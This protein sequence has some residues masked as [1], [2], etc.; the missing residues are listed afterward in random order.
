MIRGLRQMA[1]CE[2]VVLLAVAPSLARADVVWVR[3]ADHGA[4]ERAPREL[5]IAAARATVSARSLERRERRGTAPAFLASDLPVEP[6]YVQALVVR[7]FH[8][9]VVSRWL[10]AASVETAPERLPELGSLP[11]VIGVEPV[12]QA[13]ADLDLERP[14]AIVE[15]MGA[16]HAA[17]V[18][19]VPG[20]TSF[21]GYSA[22]QNELIEADRLHARGL[23][24]HGV[25]ITMLDTG[26][27]ET[28]QVFDSLRVVARR[29]FIHGDTV[30]VNQPMQDSAGQDSHGT[31]TLSVIG[32]DLPGRLVGTAFGATFA[33]GKTEDVVTE[34]PVEMDYWQA[35]AEWADSLGADVISSS[36]GYSTF[37]SPYPSYTYADM[38]GRTTVVTL[39][40]AE[41]ARRGIVV[42]TAQGNAGST[43]WHYLIAPADGDTVCAVGATDSTGAIAYFSS[44]GPSADGRVKPDVCGMGLNASVVLPS[45]DVNIVQANG[46][47]FSTPAMA[48]VAA[49]LL[50]AHPGWTPFEVIQSLRAT[51]TRF[52]NPDAQL[53]YGVARAADAVDWTP[54]TVFASPA[55]GTAALVLAGPTPLVR[56]EKIAFW[57]RAGATSGAAHVDIF[58]TRGRRL[59]TL[60]AGEMLAGSERLLPW[61]GRNE[62]GRRAAAGV[63][64]VRFDAPGVHL[65]RRVVLL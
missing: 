61:D 8:V 28:H 40:A 18:D 32:A 13:R 26:F 7:G 12:A 64:F 54:S 33:L 42:V 60:F 62:A 6:R 16:A 1:L 22:A 49:L 4:L 59:R 57:A 37:D 10:N 46:T 58:D 38:N 19:T 11:F 24:G 3:F 43:S 50:E 53:G 36:L 20:D 27:R 45:S 55:P 29:D 34:T 9:R 65:G 25:L 23:S 31:M 44:F 39:A 48:G 41:A 47:S 56:G 30:V 63:Y 14:M 35:G 21:Y 5:R 17:A 15:T 2:L 51:A 52:A